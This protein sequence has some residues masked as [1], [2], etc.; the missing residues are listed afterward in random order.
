M[1]T[2][3][4]CTEGQGNP[5][6]NRK[7]IFAEKT[8]AHKHEASGDFSVV[9][10]NLLGQHVMTEKLYFYLPKSHYGQISRHERLVEEL[11]YL[12][13]DILCLQEVPEQYHA[14]MLE[15]ALRMRGYVGVYYTRD[16]DLGL[17]IYV[18]ED[19]FAIKAKQCFRLDACADS[20]VKVKAEISII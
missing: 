5:I 8:D 9:T 2:P 20:F 18:K 19:K 15:P 3:V 1:D 13:G 11:T 12:D 6:L 16:D 4:C 10:Y 14:S 17:A 7:T